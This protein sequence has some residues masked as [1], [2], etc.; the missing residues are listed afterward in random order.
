MTDFN[1]LAARYVAVWNEAEAPARRKFIEELWTRDGAQILVDAPEDLRNAVGRINFQLPL[2]EV[3]GYDA[4]ESRI[5]RAYE[6]FGRVGLRFVQHGTPTRL[7]N[8]VVAVRWS[9]AKPDGAVV[10]GGLDIL[11]L[12]EDGRIRT[13][14]QH[15]GID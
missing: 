7:L 1:E 15:I 10:G 5:E 4:L 2:L 11:A 12:D 9:M 6:M 8:Q 14:H 13:D 3:R